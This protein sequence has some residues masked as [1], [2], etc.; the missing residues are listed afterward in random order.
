M[1]V[2]CQK[3]RKCSEAELPGHVCSQFLRCHH[4]HPLLSLFH[5]WYWIK[6]CPGQCE[7]RSFADGAICLR[8]HYFTT[9]AQFGTIFNPQRSVEEDSD[10]ET[11]HKYS[12]EPSIDR[13]ADFYELLI[14]RPMHS[15]DFFECL[16]RWIVLRLIER[17]GIVVTIRI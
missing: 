13:S 14:D 2:A 11:H 16:C 3:N 8:R 5:E 9:A 17:V 7:T 12:T 6:E 4:R 15:T 10:G 1:F